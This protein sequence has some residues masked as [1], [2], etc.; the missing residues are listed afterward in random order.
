MN[1]GVKICADVPCHL[2]YASSCEVKEDC[3]SCP[4]LPDLRVVRPE[5]ALSVSPHS[6]AALSCAFDRFTL[7]SDEQSPLI[8]CIKAL[9]GCGWLDA[10]LCC[11]TLSRFCK[12][13]QLIFSR[14][15]S[16]ELSDSAL[17]KKSVE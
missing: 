1:Q 2:P 15:Q 17:E 13:Q 16:L 11:S 9:V 12:V 6:V 4:F 7:L 14:T 10:F 8:K 3:R 5:V